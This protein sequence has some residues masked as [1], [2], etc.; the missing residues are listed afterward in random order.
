M[1]SPEDND[2][3]IIDPMR[4]RRQTVKDVFGEVLPTGVQKKLFHGIRQSNPPSGRK[5][6]LRHCGHDEILI[7]GS[8]R[9]TVNDRFCL[10][11]FS[12]SDF[13]P[14]ASVAGHFIAPER[15]FWICGAGYCAKS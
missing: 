13:A 7:W 11:E 9:V 3:G 14:F 6:F 1:N 8:G 2:P 15:G 12:K 4:R 5:V 10:E